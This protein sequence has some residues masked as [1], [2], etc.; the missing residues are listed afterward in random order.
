[1]A[2]GK[3]SQLGSICAILLG[4]S[5]EVVGLSYVLLPAEQQGGTLLHDPEK[6]LVSISRSP[7]L[8]TV[9]H[10]AFGLGALLGIALVLAV[11]DLARR[12]NE[13]WVRWLSALGLFGFAVTA[14]DNFKIVAAEP[15]RAARY[16]AGEA[17]V[18]A[19]MQETDY[20]VSIDPHMWLGYGLVGLWVLGTS[21]ILMKN[22]AVPRVFGLL[23]AVI[24]FIYF[25]VEVGTVLRNE[26]W[27]TAAAALGAVLAG[28]VWYIWLALILRKESRSAGISL[29]CGARNCESMSDIREKSL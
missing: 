17:V 9:H 15:I 27:L 6:F 19:I 26:S 29:F 13:T 7:V 3:T 20:L 2:N 18:K 5:Y 8:I 16:A 10:V 28:P 4:I 11:Y 24:G 1:M 23:G 22:G 21:W 14:I 12:F 25:F